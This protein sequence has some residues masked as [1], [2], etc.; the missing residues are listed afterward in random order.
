MISRVERQADADH[1]DGLTR[2]RRISGRPVAGSGVNDWWLCISQ[3]LEPMD[4]ENPIKEK[5]IERGTRSAVRRKQCRS[6]KSKTKWPQLSFEGAPLR[7][8]PI[9]PRFYRHGERSERVARRAPATTSWPKNK[10]WR[11]TFLLPSLPGAGRSRP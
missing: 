2:R 5:L 8:R 11:N 4:L 6:T 7:S 10:S 3:P 1:Q 9:S